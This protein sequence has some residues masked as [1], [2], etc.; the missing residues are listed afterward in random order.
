M[1]ISKCFGE[2]EKWFFDM[3]TFVFCFQ[4]MWVNERLHNKFVK[5]NQ[6]ICEHFSN[7]CDFAK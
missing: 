5:S 3:I 7:T 4:I 6:I 2:Q 1:E